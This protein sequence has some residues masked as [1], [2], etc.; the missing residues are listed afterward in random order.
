MVEVIFTFFV[1]VG[2]TAGVYEFL[3]DKDKKQI[4]R[5]AAKSLVNMLE[6]TTMRI[7][8]RSKILKRDLTEDEKDEVVDDYYREYKENKG[9]W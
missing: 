8:E 9:I 4:E 3:L 5:L 6:E 7:G 2:I 1:G